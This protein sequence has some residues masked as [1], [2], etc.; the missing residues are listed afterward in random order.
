VANGGQRLLLK[1]LSSGTKVAQAAAVVTDALPQASSKPAGVPAEKPVQE[2]TYSLTPQLVYG[3]YRNSPTRSRFMTTGAAFDAQY[4]ERGGIAL[5]ATHTDLKYKGGTPKL[6]Q[7]SLFLSARANYVPDG[8]PGSLTFRGDI[9][10]IGNN[11]PTNE[12][13]KVRAFAPQL[14]Y[15]S[16]DKSQYFDLG[17]AY[18]RYGGS[19]AGN[20]SLNVRQLTPTVGFAFNQGADWLQVRLYDIRFTSSVRT[21][22]KSG[23]DAVEA[24]WT[25]FMAPHSFIPEKIQISALVGERLYAVDGDAATVFNLAD[26]QRGGAAATAQWTLAPR[27]TLQLNGGYNRYQAM[28]AGLTTSY[29]ATHVYTGINAEW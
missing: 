13:N 22:N 7:N 8:L 2:W 11:D 6:R 12:T 16:F 29:S 19:N 23:T 10:Q 14:S 9:H 3:A 18:S 1:W 21:Q 27:L 5:G 24:K 17:Y 28:S 25:H 26:L 20:P 4:L 15:L